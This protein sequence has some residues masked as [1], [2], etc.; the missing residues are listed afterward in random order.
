[1]AKQR[2][3]QN[4]RKQKSGMQNTGQIDTDVFLKGMSKDPN[5]ALTDKNSWTHARNAINNSS[6][7]DVGA[8]GNE[9]ANL[10][11][12]EISYTVV[13]TIHL[14]GDKWAIYSTDNITSEI[15]IFDD[16]QCTYETLVNDGAGS[17]CPPENCL[18]FKTQYLITG[19]SKENFDCTWQVYWDDG[20]NPSRTLN[21]TNIPWKTIKVVNDDCVEY[22]PIE[23]LEIDCDLI[24]LAPFM[25][26][27]EVILS[28]SANGGQLRNGSY[29]AFI[30][31]TINE[32]QI[33]DYIGVSN[34]QSLW[35]H[36]DVAGSL[37]IKLRNLDTGGMFEEFKLVILSNN[38]NEV[39][40]KQI[41]FYSVEQT[42]IG[43]DYIDRSLKSVPIEFLPLR[44]PVYEKSDKMY[45]VNDYLI[46][47]GPYERFDFNY[48][49]FANEIET[50]WTSTQFPSDY[51]VKGGNKPTFMRDE[52][53]AFF[54]RWIYNTGERSS[55]YH[56]PGRGPEFYNPPMGA[57]TDLTPAGDSNCL[58]V[59]EQV[60][61]SYNTARYA[62]DGPFD[63]PSYRTHDGGIIFKQGY[64][65]YWESTERYPMDPVR[66]GDLCGKPIRH[67]KM[68][69]E[70][71]D[72]SLK[73][74]DNGNQVIQ[75]VG[76]K[77][78]NIA[79]PRMNP[80]T[81]GPCEDPEGEGMLVPGIVGYEILVGSRKGNKSIIAKGLAR[82][83][84]GYRL[85]PDAVG[86]DAD[87]SSYNDVL[88]V[89]S[90]YPFNDLGCDAFL[91]DP[92]DVPNA[93]DPN[94]IP[95]YAYPSRNNATPYKGMGTDPDDLVGRGWKYVY[96]NMFTFHSPDT[97]I[98][99]PF[100]SPYEIK[101]YGV[102]KGQSIGQFKV[103]EKHPQQK[104]L[105]N[106]S[107]FIAIVIGVGYAIG[108]TRGKKQVTVDYPQPM[109]TANPP[110][111]GA[112][113][114][115][116]NALGLAGQ[117]LST[118][119]TETIATASSVF[120]GPGIG[121]QIAQAGNTA[122]F[123]GTSQ[124]MIG[125]YQDGG[126]QVSYDNSN[127]WFA[128]VPA[129]LQPLYGVFAFMQQTAEGGQHIINLIYE[130]CS[131]QDYAMKYNGHGLYWDILLQSLDD[132]QRTCMRT[133]CEKAR[134]VKN[135]MQ[136]LTSKI[137]INNLFRP[138]TV[139]LIGEGYDG[140]DNIE[141]SSY[142]ILDAPIGMD[143]SRVTIG[144]MGNRTYPTRVFT[145]NIAAHYVGLK[146]NF[147]NQYGQLEQVK[148]VPINNG[149]F[150]SGRQ[151]IDNQLDKD[152]DGNIIAPPDINTRLRSDNLYGG[153]C[154]INRYTEKNTMPFF[155]DFLLGQ[156]DG[157]PYDYRL[158]GNIMFPMYWA[159]FIRYDLSNLAR[160][161]TSFAFLDTPGS[162]YGAMP[163]GFFHLDDGSVQCSNGSGIYN[164]FAG[165]DYPS[166][167]PVPPNP[168]FTVPN[169][170]GVTGTPVYN[171]DDVLIG[172]DTNG[173]GLPDNQGGGGNVDSGLE[174]YNVNS[175][176]VVAETPP[177]FEEDANDNRG[178]SLFHVKDR[179]FYTHV[180]GVQDFFVESEINV[181]Q[182]D[183]EDQKGKRHYD[184]LEYTDVNELFNAEF[185][186]IG[187]FYKYD[188]SLTYANFPTSRINSGLIQ[189]R[190]Y[191]PFVAETCLT[192]YPKRL[193]YSLQAQKEAK[194][195]FWTVYLPNNYKDFKNKVNVIKPIS[196]SGAVILFPH[197]SPA[198]F[199]G[200]DTLRTDLGTKLTIGDG[201]L[202][203][204][205]M[206]NL[207]NADTAHEYGSCESSRSVINTPAGLFYIS[208]AQGKIFQMAGKGLNNISNL[209]MKQWF[210]QY[211]PSQLIAQFPELETCSN[212][213][214]NPVAGVGCQSVY[215]PNYDL[216]YFMK[217]DYY[218]TSE[219]IDFN[220]C[221]GFVY[222]QTKCD[223][224]E[225]IPCCPEGFTYM[226]DSDGK[227]ERTF[228]VDAD[229]I[230]QE[231]DTNFDIMISIIQSRSLYVDD[232]VDVLKLLVENII[233]NFAEELANDTVRIAFH[234]FN[235]VPQTGLDL[236]NDTN[237]LYNWINNI[238][239][240]TNQDIAA[241]FQLPLTPTEIAGMQDPNVGSSGGSNPTKAFWNSLDKLYTQGRANTNK[242]HLQ[243]NDRFDTTALASHLGDGY[244]YDSGTS[245]ATP[246]TPPMVNTLSINPG[247]PG[248]VS[249]YQENQWDIDGDEIEFSLYSQVENIVS[250]YV[251]LQQNDS[252]VSWLNNNV[253]DPTS[254]YQDYN[255]NSFNGQLQVWNFHMEPKAGHPSQL[256]NDGTFPPFNE[257]T[258]VTPTQGNI[259]YTAARSGPGAGQ[260]AVGPFE[261]DVAVNMAQQLYD[262]VINP[263]DLIECP[264]GCTPVQDVGGNWMC[265]CYENAPAL[266]LVDQ[267][268]PVTF[269]DTEYFEDV[270]WTVSYDPKAK[271]WISFHD[272]HPELVLPS[273][274]HFLTTKS[275]I[276]SE[277]LCPPGY[278]YN[279]TTEKCEQLSVGEFPA[280]INVEDREGIYT[281]GQTPSASL[282]AKP[283][284]IVFALDASDSTIIQV[285][286]WE[287]QLQF[288][289]SFV[290]S[291]QAA[292]TDGIVQIGIYQWAAL[293]DVD[294]NTDTSSSGKTNLYLT[295]N[296]NAIRNFLGVLGGG[297]PLVSQ[298]SND[299]TNY[300]SVWQGI[301]MYLDDPFGYPDSSTNNIQGNSH[302]G[303]RFD[304]PDLQR[305]GIVITD[306][307]DNAV[308]VK[309]QNLAS[310]ATDQYLATLG[311]TEPTGTYG[312]NPG[313][314]GGKIWDYLY[315]NT[316]TLGLWKAFGQYA[317]TDC[318]NSLGISGFISA[319]H[320]L[321]DGTLIPPGY[322]NA[323]QEYLNSF[324]PGCYEATGQSHM[325]IRLVGVSASPT[326]NS[327]YQQG[328][329]LFQE[330]YY[331]AGLWNENPVNIVD[332]SV[333][334]SAIP[335]SS[336][337]VWI[338]NFEAP[339]TDIINNI[340]IETEQVE[341]SDSICSC[342]EFPG[343][344][345]VYMDSQGNY[346]LDEG[347]C[348]PGRFICRRVDCFCDTSLVSNTTTII[349]TGDCPDFYNVG[350]P[351][352]F[353]L[354]NNPVDGMRKMCSY[355]GLC[356]IDPSYIRGG[357]WKHNVRCDLYTNYYGENY[358]WE[359]EWVE[360]IGQNVNT[361]R[362]VEYQLESWVYK[363]N[364]ENNCGD[365]FHDL[366]FNFDETII[367]NSEQVSGLLRLDLNPK[368]NVPLITDYPIVTANDIRI[369]YSK[370]EQ[371]FRFNQFWDITNDRGEFTNSTQSIFITQLNGYIRDLNAANLN[372][373]KDQLQR[374]KFRHYY[375]K[376]LLRR[377]AS[378][379][380][381][382]VLKLA[383]TKV[384]YSFR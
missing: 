107:A 226:P 327:T 234:A 70:Q 28:S 214:D 383:N 164:E 332:D 343:F 120:G 289:D 275:K 190:D 105:T 116:G 274:N 329:F 277:P 264:V 280:T 132:G 384:N 223:G 91:H 160:Y 298:V 247:Q 111:V 229:I 252:F 112:G 304:D 130:L 4:T 155:W 216:V 248:D 242:I 137:K 257:F 267:T 15:G 309:H 299:A 100:L 162:I 178:K 146:L 218:C 174:D 169:S 373:N 144:Q 147:E 156:P 358:P 238:Y 2:K 330:A 237:E 89:T 69:D 251:D 268:I 354:Y 382:M 20:L 302:S 73:R 346:T 181:A 31:Y 356:E 94:A 293:A 319:V 316:G 273:L 361:I 359:I 168:S 29:Q 76:V 177:E 38:Q 13:G 366:D 122:A 32:Q 101:S 165:T 90:N 141:G 33:G 26:T 63:L 88:G 27:P 283:H 259:D 71:T 265:E 290:Q 364:L 92:G 314:D 188:N 118:A 295:N 21:I 260:W 204:Q 258:P 109:V 36:E 313:L 103:S 240:Q 82:N 286:V 217:K 355:D 37:D 145:R 191:D 210:N 324:A 139:A 96:K 230:E 360:A 203:S 195:D 300:W 192:H 241:P 349:E 249:F 378:G 114:A 121:Q 56:I 254:N 272:W 49:P 86:N 179:Y 279:E 110:L 170:D 367:H 158:R 46:R 301:R 180:S 227:C 163:N 307:Y 75:V 197:L 221:N 365:R 232:N 182:R 50:T 352:W 153:D 151:F 269:E 35:D 284:D 276:V 320:N 16:S 66:Y 127:S 219:C 369:L 67:H 54:I 166:G 187:N 225:Q 281:P 342:D 10:F 65:A 74:S 212:W 7:G 136:N 193:S 246:T 208:Q 175:T 22:I 368:N 205:P 239:F 196:K 305:V 371:R 297:T 149:E 335:R 207:V 380:R 55:S 148:Q 150:G 167:T 325:N 19:A 372:Y 3:K 370:E 161:I 253:F 106:L 9:P 266:G 339:A 323:G 129:L 140:D 347:T 189:P 271:A 87:E 291:L 85:P 213:S 308:T 243:I 362:S 262:N 104:L 235:E 245:T 311:L 322:P 6:K 25:D 84:K 23:P 288:I 363:G 176:G 173:D 186:A 171:D 348:G 117:Q 17:T 345:I 126:V 51:Y 99:Q 108:R 194:K 381:K 344:E 138:N 220:A 14:Y 379:S 45:V 287:A 310:G 270:S 72:A 250:S 80:E 340:A 119:G 157:F 133:R 201:G 231:A 68:P 131:F 209:G 58:D 353:T 292:I 215:D 278:T 202:F 59:E 351:E 184:W 115:G 375:N 333:G 47:S 255:S 376:I 57:V 236:T 124:F 8:I 52:V 312:Q 328:L 53:Y 42:D 337:N 357:L 44:N 183:Y 315:W 152:E 318:W 326:S 134:Y 261:D 206:Q 228:Y 341:G 142:H 1:M 334:V 306:N 98:N 244:G 321:G 285:G 62:V 256:L 282:N 18:N 81:L 154:Y 77:F 143:N 338:D 60:F 97:S 113:I 159:N 64:M 263:P 125:G 79:L 95:E 224:L 294:R 331:Q 222:N 41:G 24:R 34:V 172:Y 128:D 40:A 199:Q 336:Y 377:T 303:S 83:M 43:I 93:S 200:V 78:E 198:M 233:N 135:T 5:A 48:Q 374:K 11:C 350:N 317:N 102:T 123:T 185:I 30:A 296:Y 12:V 39:V 61:Q 211:L